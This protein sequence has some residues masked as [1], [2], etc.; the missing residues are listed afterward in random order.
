MVNTNGHINNSIQV[1]LVR[2]LKELNILDSLTD[3]KITEV[4]INTN[5]K[6]F[7]NKLGEGYLKLKAESNPHTL[8]NLLK[9]LSS[10]DNKILTKETPNV[11]TKLWLQEQN[12]KLRIEGLINPVVS[13]PTIN[14]RKQSEYLLTLDD[15]LKQEFLNQETYNLLK[16]AVED[17]KNILIV[18]GTDTGK[19]TFTNA[20]LNVMDNLGQRI[21]AIEEIPEL[22]IKS[23]NVNR[24]Q[25][26]PNIFSS[27]Q[28][29]K[30]CMRASP[31][32]IIFGEIREGESAYEFINGLNSGHAG[33]LTTIHADDGYGGLKKL[34]TYIRQKYGN[35][36][37]EEIGTA[38][39]VIVTVKMKN[40]KRYLATVDVCKGYDYITNTYKLKNIYTA[41]DENKN[42]DI[43]KDK[44]IEYLKE[45]NNFDDIQLN[46][47][48]GKTL[49]YLEEMS[50]RR[51]YESKN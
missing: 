30:Y 33:G 15:Y 3:S 24:V 44:L 35:P 4:M 32:R 11:S 9:M 22:Q 28:A 49:E 40:F 37:S 20:L 16:K 38:V 34:E 17:K 14:I 21:I 42:K 51:S 39:N 1:S 26:I 8:I 19:T 23:D 12:L 29:L 27:L 5:N 41:K 31:E 18:G 2:M 25:V 7:V 50:L 6:I 45:K 10:L 47:L 46:I 36:M 48:K 43:E 13:N